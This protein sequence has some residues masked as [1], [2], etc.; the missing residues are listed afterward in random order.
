MPN[1]VIQCPQCDR[2]LKVPEYLLGQAVKCPTCGATFTASGGGGSAS[3]PNTPAPPQ[4]EPDL[5]RDEEEPPVK[6]QSSGR[7]RPAALDEEEEDYDDS[8]RRRSRRRRDY[9]PHRGAVILVL[10][11]LSLVIFPIILG[12]IAWVMGNNDMRE[13]RAG[14]MDPE[15]E[16]TTNAG[17]ICGMIG[18]TLGILGMCCLGL[19][20]ISIAASGGR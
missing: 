1:E 19:V 2:K 7:R 4:E 3:E 14:R 20:F 15:G 10:G 5:G 9:Q 18:T 13:I 11:I 8:P 12:P 16:G 6:R 17:R